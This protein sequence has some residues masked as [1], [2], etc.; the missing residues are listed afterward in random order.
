VISVA[1]KETFVDK[2]TGRVDT[3][4]HIKLPKGGGWVWRRVG[5]I[6]TPNLIRKEDKK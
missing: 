3:Y 1:K 5:D 4:E 6:R 2:D